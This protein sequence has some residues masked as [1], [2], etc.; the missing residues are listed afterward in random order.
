MVLCDAEVQGRKAPDVSLP[1]NEQS[2]GEILEAMAC[3]TL[4]SE[5]FSYFF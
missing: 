3:E 5:R 1:K 2:G 4:I